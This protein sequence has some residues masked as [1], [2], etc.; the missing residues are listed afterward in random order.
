MG[1]LQPLIARARARGIVW[2]AL[3]YGRW[4][5]A[6][7]LRRIDL[8]AIG[9]EKRRLI[10]GDG[11]VSSLHHTLEENR[12]I[13][14]TYDWSGGGEEW[15]QAVKEYRGLDPAA[16]KQTL[17]DRVMKR[18]IRP[19]AT[20]LEIGP[21]AGRWTEHLVGIAG[22]LHVADISEKCLAVCRERFGGRDGIRFHLIR[23]DGLSFLDP[24]SID[25]VWSY[26]VFVHITPNDV[27]RYVG[28]FRRILRPGGVAVIHHSGRYR[29][30][31]E[32]EMS[33]RS[34]LDAALFA[35]MLAR[36]GL[37]IVEQDTSLPHKPGDVITV[38]RKPAGDAA[39]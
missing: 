25:C 32:A 36:H 10:T 9:V 34:H 15:T 23:D 11:T 3:W 26:D 35:R 22:V 27:E 18:W 20:T 4:A 39:E 5:L 38:F 37:E 8:L 19:G 16:W 21:G 12:R 30:A 14:N 7:A 24:E 29:T 2:T 13:W 28:D 31:E 6:H 33:Y 1:A 17:I